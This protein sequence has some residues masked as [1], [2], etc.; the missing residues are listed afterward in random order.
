MSNARHYPAIRPMP[1]SH[2]LYQPQPFNPALEYRP[3]EHLF[4]D[5]ALTQSTFDTLAQ[6]WGRRQSY[7]VPESQYCASDNSDA[8]AESMWGGGVVGWGDTQRKSDMT[9]IL[10]PGQT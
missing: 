2:D 7:D 5:P 1:E 6:S 9:P 3:E 10:D 8:S 4:L